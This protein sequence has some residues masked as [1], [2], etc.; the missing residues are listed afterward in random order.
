MSNK[1][2]ILVYTF[3]LVIP[4]VLSLA[5]IGIS[6]N[7]LVLHSASLWRTMVGS[8]VGACIMLAVKITVERPLEIILNFVHNKFLRF[9]VNSFW[10]TESKR[11]VGANLIVDFILSGIATWGIRQ[12]FSPDRIMG[13]IL[14]IVL[15]MMFASALIGAYLE[16]D[17]LSVDGAE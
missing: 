9:L 1:K 4:Y 7:A 14:G 11:K 3:L 5:L 16:Y 8:V 12:I 10:I 6:F 15:A 2:A 17:L 13:D